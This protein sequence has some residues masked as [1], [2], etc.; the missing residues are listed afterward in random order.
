MVQ[1]EAV[2]PMVALVVVDIEVHNQ[3]V[4]VILLP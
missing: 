3:V 1:E 4:Q 2:E